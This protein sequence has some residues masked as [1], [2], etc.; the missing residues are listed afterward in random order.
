MRLAILFAIG[1]LAW[2]LAVK[3]ASQ[4]FVHNFLAIGGMM[5]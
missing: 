5:T 4:S 2:G 3:W 1:L